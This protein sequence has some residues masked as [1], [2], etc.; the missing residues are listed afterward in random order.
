MEF[1]VS[2]SDLAVCAT[3]LWAIFRMTTAIQAI[4]QN[5][6]RLN[7]DQKEDHKE[8]AELLGRISERLTKVE[9]KL[10][11]HIEDDRIHK[12]TAK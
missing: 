4:V 5:L 2:I 10:E 11:S 12:A 9:T 1:T 3:V 7:A 8:M 6:S